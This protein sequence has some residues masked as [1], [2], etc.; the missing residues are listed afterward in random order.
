MVYCLVHA[1]CGVA[2]VL[3]VA[4]SGPAAAQNAAD[5]DKLNAEVVRLWR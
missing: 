2:F 1:V 4:A 5:T 3:A